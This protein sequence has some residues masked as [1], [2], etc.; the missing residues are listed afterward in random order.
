MDPGAYKMVYS[1]GKNHMQELKPKDNFPFS[2]R[3]SD[4]FHLPLPGAGIGI[5]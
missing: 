4:V 5:R 1:L 2:E 3:V